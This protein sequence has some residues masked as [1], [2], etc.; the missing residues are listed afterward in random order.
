MTCEPQFGHRRWGAYGRACP[1]CGAPIWVEPYWSGRAVQWPG[2]GFSIAPLMRTPVE[3]FEAA[4]VPD[5]VLQ[6]RVYDALQSD[7]RIPPTATIAVEVH[8]RVVTLTGT[9]PDKWSKH[10]IAG[11]VLA[12]PGVA[13]VDNRLEIHHRERRPA[14]TQ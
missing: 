5:D 7:P 4:L 9:V 6:D 3:R 14:S 1:R 8:N 10:L 12:V 13:D 2:E 11:D